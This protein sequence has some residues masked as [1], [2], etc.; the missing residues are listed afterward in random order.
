SSWEVRTSGKSKPGMA[1]FYN[2]DTNKSEWE[3]PAGLTREQIEALPGAHQLAPH[4][5]E[6]VA[7]TRVR[8]SHIL[9]KHE[10]SRNPTSWKQPG[11]QIKRTEAQ[12]IEDLRRF[13]DDLER[14]REEGGPSAEKLK[15]EQLAKEHSD[16]SSHENNG[17]LGKFEHDKMQKPFADAAFALEIGAISDIV[18]SGSGV[19]LIMR[20]G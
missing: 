18:K 17:D 11:V 3:P 8:A 5:L 4:Q 6:P 10:G 9:V 13:Q 20:T 15:F 2:R 14:A 1:Y 12:A 19:H 16:C 7:P